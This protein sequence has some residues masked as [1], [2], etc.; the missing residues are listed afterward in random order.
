MTSVSSHVESF[1][2]RSYDLDAGGRVGL[3]AMCRYLQEAA[4]NHAAALDVALERLGPLGL[5]WV[6]GR[7]HLRLERVPRW[8][9]EIR[10]E[11]WPSGRDSLRAT[12]DFLL[13]T[14]SGEI[15]A[16][17]TTAWSL[18]NVA[19][20]RPVKL[21]DFVLELVPPERSRAIDDAFER[22]PEPESYSLSR[23]V[24]IRRSD[25]DLNGH[26]NNARYVDLLLEAAP[27][28]VWPARVPR[29]LEIA[30]RA[31]IGP[32][33]R[34]AS[35]SVKEEGAPSSWLHRIVSGSGSRSAALARLTYEEA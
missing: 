35:E 14:E 31:E 22:I 7:L 26:V 27:D 10:V 11:T 21:P 4:S 6:L 19:R 23:E 1:R 20:R 34:I 12:R 15:F 16:R 5:A 25:I 29:S 13:G 3:S 17:A 24:P 28:E 32:G 2:M 8:G 18:V 9:E 33:D 30:F